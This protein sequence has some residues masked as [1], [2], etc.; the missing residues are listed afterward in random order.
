MHN[1]RTRVH[2]KEGREREYPTLTI[3]CT[4]ALRKVCCVN[5]RVL[6]FCIKIYKEIN[7]LLIDVDTFVYVDINIT[8]FMLGRG[9]SEKHWNEFRCSVIHDN[10]QH[11]STF[12]NLLLLG[13]FGTIFLGW[14][15][16]ILF[17]DNFKIFKFYNIPGLV[18]VLLCNRGIYSDACIIDSRWH[19]LL[20][21]FGLYRLVLVSINRLSINYNKCLLLCHKSKHSTPKM[22][23][24]H[25]IISSLY[26]VHLPTL[27]S[28]E[29]RC[30]P[31]LFI[32]M[33]SCSGWSENSYSV[34]LS[35]KTFLIYLL[36][37]KIWA[38]FCQ[39]VQNHRE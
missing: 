11:L 20:S 15:A 7:N 5:C 1:L 39:T 3:A 16:W 28:S 17:R 18:V 26:A 19:T 12:F 31:S 23:T 24:G 9:T 37:T 32:I 4:N 21:M 34:L 6:S 27:M 10:V 8:S 13:V 2:N 33:N 22:I 14:I 35:N 30:S 38:L 29:V 25:C 36:L